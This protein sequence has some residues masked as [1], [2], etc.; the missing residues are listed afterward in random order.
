MRWLCAGLLAF[1]AAMASANTDVWPALYDVT[2]VEADDVLNVRSAPDASSDVIDMLAPNAVNIEVIAV[3]D[4]RTWAQINTGEQSGWA[5]LRYLARQ[6]GQSQGDFPNITTCYGTEPFWDL[7][8][9]E[10]SAELTVLG[11]TSYAAAPIERLRSANRIDRFSIVSHEFV[12][13]IK[14]QA[15]S[16]GMSDRGFGL[17]IDLL[18]N[19]TEAA[20]H[21]SGCCTIQP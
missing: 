3:N 5:S 16:D 12:A 9:D 13:V 21:L 1:W 17:S 18:T 20:Q 8:V 2:G 7:R 10:K 6:P 11:N 14:S 15:C 4:A 19:P